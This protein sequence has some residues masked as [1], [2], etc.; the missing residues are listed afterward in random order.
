M[1]K[2]VYSIAGIIL[3]NTCAYAQSIHFSQYY[4]APLLNNP[5]NTALMPDHDYRLGV[6]FRNQWA[7]IPVPYNTFSA[8]GDFSVFKNGN[9]NNWLGLGGAFFSDKA[10]DGNLALTRIEGF[11][12]YHLS[13]SKV[14]MISAGLSFG[15]V[16][17]SV[18]FENLTFDQQWDGFS[19]NS[20]L[21]NG[22]KGYVAKTN[23]NTVGAGINYAYF[24]ADNFYLSIGAGLANVN[25][26]KESFYNMNN[27]LGMRP[28]ANIDLVRRM[29]ERFILNP[30]VYFAT[31][32]GAS[33]LVF[34]SL[35]RIYVGGKDENNT[36]VIF[37]AF[38]R[39]NESIIGAAGIHWGNIQ[40]MASYDVTTS[41][42][43][44]YNSGFGAMEFSLIYTGI[45]PS[46]AT[47]KKYYNCPR[48]F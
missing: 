41:K 22:E 47:D 26:P 10:G 6:N 45:Y 11:A 24:P 33:E 36:E 25:Q 31:Q 5:A 3:L 15:S 42:L 20:S 44:T 32:K 29:G 14:S 21:P 1:K 35:F 9:S 38:D 34:G 17:R 13:I 4:N 18:N 7:S 19:F 27:N 39:L 30:S 46:A 23:Y 2:I 40:V 48:F 28:S 16:Q 43:A 37:G 8:F 12:A